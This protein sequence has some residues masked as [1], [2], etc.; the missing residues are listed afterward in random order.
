MDEFP[1]GSFRIIFD[2]MFHV[3][4]RKCLRHFQAVGVDQVFC[5]RD[6]PDRRQLDLRNQGNR[7]EQVLLVRTAVILF[8]RDLIAERAHQVFA[9]RVK[10][11]RNEPGRTEMKAGPLD[12]ELFLQRFAVVDRHRKQ[13][14]QRTRRIAGQVKSLQI[15]SQLARV[16][17]QVSKRG[18][19]IIDLVPERCLRDAAIAEADN[20]VAHPRPLIIVVCVDLLV[21]SKKPAAVDVDH[22][23]RA[24]IGARQAVDVKQVSL[25]PIIQ[26]GDVA[27]ENQIARILLLL[28]DAFLIAGLKYVSPQ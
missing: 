4:F 19:D 17:R 6:L 24:L 5:A 3:R 7:I 20:T 14:Q 9:L 8:F 11:D 22:D 28:G 12:P 13:T 23:R 15:E 27:L 1:L 26:I 2:L 25:I 16:S 10:H 21:R 18:H